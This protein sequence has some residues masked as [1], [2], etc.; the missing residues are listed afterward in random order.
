DADF[1]EAERGG[2]ADEEHGDA[3]GEADGALPAAGHEVFVLEAEVIADGLEDVFGA[4][5][6]DELAIEVAEGVLGEGG[7]S[8]AAGEL[9]VGGDAGHGAFK[10]AHVLGHAAGDPVDD[11]FAEM[12]AVAKGDGAEDLAAGGEIGRVDADD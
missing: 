2:L 12:N 7:V 3:T 10:L 6:G 8:G 9:D 5:G 11:F 1:G 4:D